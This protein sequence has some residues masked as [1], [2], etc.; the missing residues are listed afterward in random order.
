M[1]RICFFRLSD[2]EAIGG[3]ILAQQGKGTPRKTAF[4]SM[5]ASAVVGMP[6]QFRS[7]AVS[8]AGGGIFR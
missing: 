7:Q 2:S 4:I 8:P 5:I 1:G 6:S 3:L